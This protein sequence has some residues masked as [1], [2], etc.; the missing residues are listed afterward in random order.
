MNIKKIVVFMLIAISIS[1]SAF[2]QNWQPKAI[3]YNGDSG[4]FI[5]FQIMDSI[6]VKLIGRNEVLRENKHLWTLYKNEKNETLALSQKYKAEREISKDWENLYLKSEEQSKLYE[7]NFNKQ[8][9]ITKNIKKK[10]FKNGVL[11]FGGGV[12]IGVSIL[13]I[14]AL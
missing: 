12:A 2:S 10:S 11:W 9:E 14:L 4:L 5:S 3:T 6:S 13:T 1:G 7:I 8:K